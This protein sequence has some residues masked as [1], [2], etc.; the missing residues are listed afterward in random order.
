[1]K[2]I[3]KEYK[4]YNYEE[5]SEEAKEKA[6]HSHIENN[7]YPFLKEEIMME[8]YELLKK[9][10]IKAIEVD[11]YFSL[12]YCQGD[13]VMFFGNFEWKSY[14]VNIKHSG[15]YYHYNSKDI[16][17]NSIK[18]SKYASEEIEAEFNELYVEICK[19]L[20][21]YGYKMIENDNSEETFKEDCAC[22]EYTF[23]E[24]GVMMNS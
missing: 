14:Q 10:K 22:N 15:H 21:T 2:I 12:S 4:L 17:I 9:S 20:D 7:D 5:L 24:D 13:G 8:L 3:Q 1:M 6:L 19:K 23:L 18:T 16:D 11:V